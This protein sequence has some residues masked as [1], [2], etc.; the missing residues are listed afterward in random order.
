MVAGTQ[1]ALSIFEMFRGK[2]QVAQIESNLPAR[3]FWQQV[4]NGYTHGKYEEVPARDDDFQGM[5]IF[6]DNSLPEDKWLTRSS[7]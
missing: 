1:V 6:F 2:W 7:D 4:I 5:I 3:K